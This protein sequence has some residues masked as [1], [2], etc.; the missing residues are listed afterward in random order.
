MHSHARF[1]LLIA[2]FVAANHPVFQA[3]QINSTAATVPSTVE[4][5]IQTE[6]KT[7]PY[8][9]CT[10]VAAY[11]YGHDMSLSCWTRG[12]TIVETK[13]VLIIPSLKLILC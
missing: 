6:C 7:C 4:D 9:L 2:P 3:R 1:G 10:N 8:S 11:E 12:D 13:C 5:G